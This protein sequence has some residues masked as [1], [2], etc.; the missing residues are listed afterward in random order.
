VYSLGATLY[1]LLTGKSPGEGDVGEILRRVQAGELTP[2][3]QVD[4]SIDPALEAVCL[5]AMARDPADRYPSARGLA[6]EAER[7]AA[8]EP[9]SAWREPPSRRARRWARRHVPLVVG[10]VTLLVASTAAL[11][12]GAALLKGANASIEARR[13]EAEGNYRLAREAVDG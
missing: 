10:I 7:R 8:D 12:I 4:P 11:A 1:C 6:E 5:K 3:R 13:L 9:P 2:P